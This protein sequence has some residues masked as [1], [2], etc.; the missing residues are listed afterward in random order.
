M[1]LFGPEVIVLLLL[2]P[3]SCLMPPDVR[4][5][6]LRKLLEPDQF[7]AVEPANRFLSCSCFQRSNLMFASATFE[8]PSDSCVR[9]ASGT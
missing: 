2:M 5:V 3:A 7:D 8:V 4:E 6:L 9:S 1:V